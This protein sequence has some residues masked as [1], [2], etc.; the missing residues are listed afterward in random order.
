MQR[1]LPV[2]LPAHTPATHQQPQASV[3]EHEPTPH[4]QQP[5]ASVS[6]HE[7]RH[8]GAAEPRQGA[9]EALMASRSGRLAQ[10]DSTVERKSDAR[11]GR[12]TSQACQSACKIDPKSA[13]NFDPLEGRRAVVLAPSQRVGVAE[14]GR[15]RV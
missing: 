14:T 3:C 9:Q 11:C 15:A 1:A 8:S 13:S 7:A 12:F 4:Y 6:E 5:Q 10:I 2:L